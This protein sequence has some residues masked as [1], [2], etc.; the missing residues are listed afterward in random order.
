MEEREQGKRPGWERW[1]TTEVSP[2]KEPLPQVGGGTETPL[3]EPM[4]RRERFMINGVL[5][6]ALAFVGV[7]VPT[8]V[9][10]AIAVWLGAAVVGVL[11][12]LL[13][14]VAGVM[15]ARIPT[16]VDRER[17]VIREALKYGELLSHEQA[18][19]R[20]RRFHLH[21]GCAVT[22][23]GGVGLVIALAAL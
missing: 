12:S 23:A 17:A 6:A 10:A 18:R 20:S 9:V 7:G 21:L 3:H 2:G 13:V 19:K 4:S 16:S 14:I 15:L 22:L 5:P 1:D 11:V 8:A